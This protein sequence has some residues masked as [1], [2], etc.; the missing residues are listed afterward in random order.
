MNNREE[1]ERFF[2]NSM[3]AARSEV[4]SCN[5]YVLY[6]DVIEYVSECRWYSRV[7]CPLVWKFEHPLIPL[8][9]AILQRVEDRNIRAAHPLQITRT[10]SPLAAA[11][12]PDSMLDRTRIV[13]EE[14]HR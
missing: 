6:A 4:P 13:R 12:H 9:P 2:G 3:L 10:R 7:L 8:H 14:G 5:T 11:Q 1:W